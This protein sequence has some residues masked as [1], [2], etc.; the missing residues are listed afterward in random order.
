MKFCSDCGG[1]VQLE[2][3][4]GDDRLRHVCPSCGAI[5]YQNP[6]MVVGCIP[7]WRGRIL[8]CRR[9]IEPCYGEWTLPAGYLENHET[10][11]EG[12]TRETLEEAGARV[13]DLAPYG[14]YSLPFVDQVYFMFRASLLDGDFSPGEESLDVRLYDP[15]HIPWDELAFTV[16]RETLGR[17]IRD[18]R[19]GEFPFHVVDIQD[20]R[21]DRS[22]QK[23]PCKTSFIAEPS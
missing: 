9:A 10:A 4:E 22:N 23:H 15:D 13:G 2:I 11:A 14:M 12:A 6:K 16:M 19:T 17:W 20:A 5:H 7:E 21:K 8:L 3:P 18:R 1:P